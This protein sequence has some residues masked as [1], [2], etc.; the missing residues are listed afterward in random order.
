MIGWVFV[1]V[2]LLMFVGAIAIFWHGRGVVFVD[3]QPSYYIVEDEE[4]VGRRALRYYPPRDHRPLYKE[5]VDRLG[6]LG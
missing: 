3:P 5:M 4:P 2:V 1:I 6:S